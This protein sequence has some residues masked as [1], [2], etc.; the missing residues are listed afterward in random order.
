[1][2]KF[3]DWFEEIEVMSPRCF[4]FWEELQDYINDVKDLKVASAKPIENWLRAAY[5]AGREHMQ[6][7]AVET[8]MNYK[9]KMDAGK[10]H[11]VVALENLR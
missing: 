8:A 11:I 9:M 5:L 4:R 6:D 2:Q 10:E 7:A 1:M 3:E